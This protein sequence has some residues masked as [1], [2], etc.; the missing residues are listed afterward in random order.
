MSQNRSFPQI[1]VKIKIIWNHHLVYLFSKKIPHP[2]TFRHRQTVWGPF[3]VETL[4]KKLCIYWVLP[5]PSNSDHKDYYMFSR[6]F[7]LTFTFHCYREGAISNVYNNKPWTNTYYKK[8]K[9]KPILPITKHISSIFQGTQK[10]LPT[11]KVCGLILPTKKTRTSEFS[12][13]SNHPIW[14]EP[15]V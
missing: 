6:G 15:I 9:T 8:N 5:P 4:Q 12:G 14:V 10:S 3:A 2:Q 1:G 13:P 7:L 11:R